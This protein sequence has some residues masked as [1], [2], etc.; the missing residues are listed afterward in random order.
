[1]YAVSPGTIALLA[2][3]V[4]VLL[5]L[6]IGVAA[7]LL[8]L[9]NSVAVLARAFTM[10][11]GYALL[12]GYLGLSCLYLF[13]HWREMPRKQAAWACVAIGLFALLWVSVFESGPN[14]IVHQTQSILSTFETRKGLLT[15]LCIVNTVRDSY[16]RALSHKVDRDICKNEAD[17]LQHLPVVRDDDV[18]TAKLIRQLEANYRSVSCF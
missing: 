3:Q 17:F 1:M 15:R 5:G 10:L 4:S 7:L 8:P 12:V 14:A 16:K 9:A 6:C 13:L 2:F 11:A 18:P